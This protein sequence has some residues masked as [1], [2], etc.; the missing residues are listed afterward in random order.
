[1]MFL[2]A[3]KLAFNIFFVIRPCKSLRLGFGNIGPA[4]L[5][6]PIK[7]SQLYN[8]IR[9]VLRKVNYAKAFSL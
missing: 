5:T 7:T 1:M 2:L 6:A 4:Y 9:Y 3:K 8:C